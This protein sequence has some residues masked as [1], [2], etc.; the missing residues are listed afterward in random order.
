MQVLQVLVDREGFRR[1]RSNALK[2]STLEELF[3]EAATP[4]SRADL[5]VLPA[6]YLTAASE[7]EVPARIADVARCAK[8]N[9]VAVV[10]GVDL[11]KGK[12]NGD[13]RARTRRVTTG[14]IPYWGVA[15]DNTGATLGVWRQQSIR[16]KDA[17]IAPE[18]AANKRLVKIAGKTVAILVCGEIFNATYRDSMRAETFDV[19]IDV[20]HESMSTGVVPALTN[21]VGK[22]NRWALHSHHVKVGTAQAHG[23]GPGGSNVGVRST[24]AWREVPTGGWRVFTTTRVV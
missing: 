5:V 21:I 1:V 18:L 19:V 8:N 16:S 7:S 4:A 6:G 13:D 15:L 12:R 14:R 17:G 23:I 2:L 10:F 20:G 22:G 24:G 3:R 9:G 11:P